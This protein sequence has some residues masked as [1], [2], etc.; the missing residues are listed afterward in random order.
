MKLSIHRLRPMIA[1]LA[2]FSA[3][4]VCA[5]TPA[6]APLSGPAAHSGVQEK[7]AY[8][9]RVG[10]CVAC[11]TAPN[12]RPFAGGL[13]LATPFGTLYSTN[14]T[15]DAK[16]GI[17]SWRYE[18]FA[19]AV[20]EGVAKD[21]HRLYPAMPYPSY[22]K[23]D[24]A[25]MRAL[26]AYF[27]QGVAP[28]SA[29]NREDRLRFP[30]SVRPLMRL[31]NA[32]Y[33]PGKPYAD[34][35]RRNV[36]WNRGAYLVQGLAHCGACHT[37]RGSFGQEAAF[38]E[39][40]S[41]A[42]LSGGSVAGWYAPSLREHPAGGASASKAA[43]SAYLR[44]GRSADG[45]AFGPM[46]EVIDHSLQYLSDQDLDAIAAYLSSPPLGGR[47]GESSAPPAARD[48]ANTALALRAGHPANA[49]AWL[50]LNNCSACHRSDGAGAMPTFPGLAGN[51]AVLGA[52]PDSLIHLVLSG[53]HM[54][55]T[56]RAPTPL[57]M[58]A[59]GWRLSDAQVAEVLSFVRASW[60]NRASAV[61]AE[62]VSRVRALALGSP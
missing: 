55:S 14:I 36:E 31:W 26:Y 12:G 38:D 44:S 60:G 1:A 10:D 15:P 53:S 30:Y 9:A 16:T 27:M 18:D 49:G 35:P 47:P 5:G 13:S 3:P 17:G 34:D 50:Y 19:R 29:V 52:N 40:G 33:A 23:V 11:H 8:L 46:T 42:F 58:P 62:A 48:D 45:A 51:A 37:P 4:F 2:L 32:L 41:E 56:S 22:A 54:P 6:A 7:G 21:G 43:L 28:V 24:E 61:S 39:R 57:A 25:D 20:R 59:F